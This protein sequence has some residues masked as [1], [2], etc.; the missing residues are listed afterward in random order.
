MNR[1]LL[2]SFTA[3]TFFQIGS[4]QTTEYFESVALNSKTFTSNGQGFTLTNN[5]LVSS[6]TGA[7]VDANTPASP[8]GNSNRYIDNFGQTATNQI[9]SIKTTNGALINV[10]ELY[11]YLASNANGDLL[12]TSGSITFRGKLAGSQIFSIAIASPPFTFP[13]SFTNFQGFSKLDLALYGF[14]N[15]NIDEL[16]IQIGGPIV[17]YA[18]DNFRWQAGNLSTTEFQKSKISIYPNPSHDIITISS[19]ADFS[20]EI[21]YK[22]LDCNSREVKRGK[23][24]GAET[25][26]SIEELHQ[27]AYFLEIYSPKGSFTEKIIKL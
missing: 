5:F 24:N 8:S 27:G 10:K 17:Y 16:E 19:S 23:I 22:V 3:L 11:Y 9:N 6:I 12:A 15:S 2:L 20:E 13:S 7:G 14:A 18:I 21:I 1:K 25:K 26:L 4:A